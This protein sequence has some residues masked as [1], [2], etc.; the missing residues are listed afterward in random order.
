LDLEVA[1][2]AANSV[3]G[4]KDNGRFM[5]EKSLLGRALGLRRRKTLERAVALERSVREGHR[6]CVS[7][8]TEKNEALL[9]EK[10]QQPEID[11]AYGASKPLL[12]QD[13]PGPSWLQQFR[14]LS[15]RY[16]KEH[17]RKRNKL[18]ISFIQTLINAVLIG[19]V[20]LQI[21]SSQTSVSRRQP[22]LQ[23]LCINQGVFGA[24]SIINAF[25]EERGLMLRERASGMYKASAYFM[26]KITVDA[27]V[28]IPMIVTFS[29]T[30]Y[31]LIGL[32]DVAAKFIV[33]LVFMHLCY[34][35]ATGLA[36]MIGALCK[37][38]D[39]ATVALSLVLEICRLYGGFF[40]SPK[41]LPHYFSW[42]DALSYVKYSYVGI[43][44]NENA[45][46]DL[47]CRPNE[48]KNGVCPYTSGWQ[49]VTELGLDFITIGG[50]AGVLIGYI[51]F[52]RA[53]AY[54]GVR[55]IKSN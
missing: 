4:T 42:L 18:V 44:L 15:E 51:I 33:F 14:I 55:Y 12:T 26:S 11:L 32:Q 53:V 40:L 19:T 52:T 45:G 3:R 37:T 24:F 5:D 38:T 30:T 10:F 17:W 31:Y 36:L 6:S 39:L 41:N 1:V 13:E 9:M 46:L 43:S 49:K 50:C 21:G 22:V 25:P 27:L 34:F 47:Y 23:F 8:I 28:Q 7:T 16:F 48:L 54:L 29:V 35:S 20:F 2:V